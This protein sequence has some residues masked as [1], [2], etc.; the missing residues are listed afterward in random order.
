MNKLIE[1][2]E[3][4]YLWVRE[5]KENSTMEERTGLKHLNREVMKTDYVY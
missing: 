3:N 5:S 2:N 1:T 4:W